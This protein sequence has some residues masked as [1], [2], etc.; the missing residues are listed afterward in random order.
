[1][2]VNIKHSHDIISLIITY[3]LNTDENVKNKEGFYEQLHS[4]LD[5]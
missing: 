3:G 4:I 2:T 5:K 1:M